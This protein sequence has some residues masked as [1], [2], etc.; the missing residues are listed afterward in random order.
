VVTAV[1]AFCQNG[2]SLWTNLGPLLFFWVLGTV[3]GWLVGVCGNILQLLKFWAEMCR[4][5][6]SSTCEMFE[7]DLRC[8]DV[9]QLPR[10]RVFKF[11]W[12]FN[13][14]ARRVPIAFH[15]LYIAR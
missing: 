1:T 3:M 5:R 4:Y 8:R 2:G 13:V 11:I 10:P 12:P 6:K 15:G 9:L 7:F 14:T